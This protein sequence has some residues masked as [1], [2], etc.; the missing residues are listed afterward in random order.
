MFGEEPIANAKDGT[1]IFGVPESQAHIH[2]TGFSTG[3]VTVRESGGATSRT[4]YDT[5]VRD[6]N[7]ALSQVP[8]FPKGLL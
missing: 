2:E 3:M 4:P 5:S 1:P 7:E 6:V 8:N